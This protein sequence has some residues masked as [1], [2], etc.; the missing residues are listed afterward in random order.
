LDNIGIVFIIFM[1]DMVVTGM[2][3]PMVTVVVVNHS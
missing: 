1:E 2:A 3:T